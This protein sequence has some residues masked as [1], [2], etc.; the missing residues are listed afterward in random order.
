[1]KIS[2]LISAIIMV[3]LF[4]NLN[5]CASEVVISS[6]KNTGVK[7]LKNRLFYKEKNGY[8]SINDGEKSKIQNLDKEA[9]MNSSKDTSAKDLKS[10]LFYKEKNGYLSIND[11]E[12][13]KIQNLAND[14]ISFL[15]QSKTE[16]EVVS[17]ILD[18]AKRSGYIEFQKD[19]KYNPG[20]KVY[21]V[22]RNKNIVLAII[23][24]D[25]CKDGFRLS[26]SHIDSPRLD[27]KQKPLFENSELAMLKTHYY[28]G[29]KKYQWTCMPLALHGRFTLKDGSYLDVN[30]GEKDDE[31]RFYISDLLP[32]LAHDQM[33]KPMS[34]A[35]SGEDLNVLIG[36]IPFK[37]D[38]ESELVKLNIMNILN[39]KYGIDESDFTCAELEFVP[40][41]KACDVGFDR[42]LIGG[43]GHDD[44]SCS[45]ASFSAIMSMNEVPKH[46]CVAMFADKEEIGS[47][48][49]TGMQSMFLKYFLSDLASCF[50]IKG[51]DAISKSKAL[52]TD[53]DAA[54]DPNYPSSFDPS[55]S[56]Y[57]NKGA[58]ITKYT[59]S[60]GKYSSSD[61][62]S[63]FLGF[64]RN[65]FDKNGVR[66]QFGSLG[67]VDTGGGGTV[68]KFVA[69]L[70]MDVVDMG[71]PV[72]SMHSPFEI[73]SKLDLYELTKGINVFLKN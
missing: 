36:S 12:K 70:N 41:F 22:N 19:K 21:L 33:Q 18:K 50:G 9:I 14:Y 59:G 44:K 49:N 25:Q 40:A 24:E 47:D 45:F 42:S 57:L 23:G 67:K 52:S 8:L 30:I 62:S 54:Y 66:Y 6:S 16:R 20:D 69:N 35:I 73:I 56:A 32:H 1:M 46:T 34:K 4:S 60:G 43:Y 64:V 65:L 39:Q 31:P 28:G 51:R 17:F 68:A 27:L 26:I 10:K 63:E 72:L 29:I 58:V 48:G 13:D 3:P 15:N 5:L 61:A 2:K 71:V 38:S 53:V 37:S 11:G 7:A 55:N